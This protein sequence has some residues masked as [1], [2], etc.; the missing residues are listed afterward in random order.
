MA[1]KKKRTSR[2]IILGFFGLVIVLIMVA[3]MSPKEPTTVF[4]DQVQNHTLIAS[5][6]ESGTVEPSVEVKI[7]PDVSGEIVELYV[8]EGDRVKKGDLLCVIRPDNYR[9]LVDQ[10]SASVNGATASQMQAMA[11]ISQARANYLQDSANFVRSDQLYRERTISKVDW[12]AAKLKREI[13]ASQVVAAKQTERAA[14]FQMES[15]KAS[16]AQARQN[17][18]RTAIHASMD[19]TVTR[20]NVERGER[21][22]GTMQM[23]GTEIMR[24]ADL[25]TMQVKVEINENDIIH[26]RI[27]DSATVEVDAYRDKKFKGKVTEIAYSATGNDALSVATNSDQITLFTVKVEIEG[28]SYRNDAQMMRGI[29][30]D[31]SPFRPGM[32]AQVEIYTERADNVPAVPSQS[33]TIRRNAMDENEE[34]QEIVFMVDEAGKVFSRPVKLGI[35]DDKYLEITEG[36]KAGETIIV[37]PPGLLYKVLE[38]GMV[39]KARPESEMKKGGMDLPTSTPTDEE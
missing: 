14:F 28:S 10:A 27:G 4:T 22:V 20:L 8:K 30:A 38:D 39:V 18:D 9:A 6:S 5:V 19:G 3:V 15:A 36:L 26:L 35:S 2:W 21:V 25:G 13:S 16:L 24:I 11:N 7:A 31:Q 12:E 1:R 32:S 37:G 23:A 34:P 33:V 17:L 29:A